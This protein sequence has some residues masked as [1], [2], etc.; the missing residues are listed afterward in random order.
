MI[1]RISLL[2]SIPWKLP[3][4]VAAGLALAATTH[5]ASPGDS[6]LV[7][8]LRAGGYVIVMRHASSP[9]TT[10]DKSQAD[11]GNT[12]LERQ[13]DEAGSNTARAMGE[14]F[15]ALHIPFGA[16]LSSPAYRARETLRLAGVEGVETFPQLNESEA[17]MQAGVGV[18]RSAWLR[19]KA[20][21]T[22]RAGTNTI[23]VTHM[24]NLVGAFG[25][26]AK[27]MAAGEALVF[28]PN[29]TSTPNVVARV[30]IEEWPRLVH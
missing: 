2:T 16:I 4:L 10:P 20:A 22:P 11:P 15:R 9:P 3:A 21:G 23:I 5:A 27:G 6:A 12:L 26:S 29:G 24:P 19:E 13:L 8:S 7:E 30:R 17:G 1:A 28:L 14:A 18:A 25:D